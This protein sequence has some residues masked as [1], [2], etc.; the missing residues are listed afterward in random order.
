MDFDLWPFASWAFLV[1]ARADSSIG[2]PKKAP[3]AFMGE[4]VLPNRLV[5]NNLA[6]AAVGQT[7]VPE[8]EPWYPL[9]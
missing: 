5:G 4:Q 1:E 8:M 3:E 2:Q 9:F 7:W 6:C